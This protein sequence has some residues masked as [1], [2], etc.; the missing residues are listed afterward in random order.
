MDNSLILIVLFA[1][2]VLLAGCAGSVPQK[3]YDQLKI[4]CADE[5]QSLQS[6]LD[7][8]NGKAASASQKYS[9]C[10]SAK[11]A[12]E[13]RLGTKDVE[14]A[15]LRGENGLLVQARQK[16]EEIAAYDL[17]L[18]YYNDGFGPGKVLNTYRLNRIDTQV[19]SLSD[20]QLLV[21][22]NAVRNCNGITDCDNAKAKFTSEIQGKKNALALEI[23]EIVKGTNSTASG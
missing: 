3:E 9:E 23:A 7:S 12:A 19:R 4:S 15:K 16:A 17:A 2:S 10:I 14:N 21:L 1:S 11:Q 6:E 8:A 22:W 5:K 13:T 18:Q 20:A